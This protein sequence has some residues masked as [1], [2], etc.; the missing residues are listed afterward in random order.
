MT[1]DFDRDFALPPAEIAEHKAII[2][3]FAREQP[4]T[5]N[6]GAQP[7]LDSSEAR[8]WPR[9]WLATQFGLRQTPLASLTVAS[10][11]AALGLATSAFARPPPPAP[12]HRPLLLLA[13]GT[14]LAGL[15][16]VGI[17]APLPRFAYGPLV[18]LPAWLGAV[19]LDRW[20]RARPARLPAPRH[21]RAGALG[22]WVLA[23]AV[24]LLTAMPWQRDSESIGA[25]GWPWV[26]RPV[27]VP[28]RTA[29]GD[30]INW[31]RRSEHCWW[32][33]PPCIQYWDDHLD[34]HV[35]PPPR[36]TR[37]PPGEAMP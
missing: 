28:R 37:H 2:A 17:T 13:G 4:W 18:A 16:F 36:L 23:G 25:E 34:R 10:L 19:A 31:P 30:L 3:R 27:I 26:D 21:L 32:A 7:P 35:G 12:G 9:R 24:G 14:I 5:E 22:L 8:G 6:Q 15:V 33:D 20:L 29:H 11:L 1:C